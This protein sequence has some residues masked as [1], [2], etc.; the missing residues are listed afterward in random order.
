MKLAP[1]QF[2]NFI[3]PHNPQVFSIEFQRTM[4]LH[5]IP[6]GKHCLQNLG[7]NRRVMKGEGEF[8]GA[9]AYSQFKQ[10]AS[11]FYEETPGVLVHPL[12][13]S[14]KVYFVEL[15]LKQEPREN[16]VRYGFCFWEC[17]DALE[18][19]TLTEVKKPE[20]NASSGGQTKAEAARYHTV[21][22]G[23][24]LWKIAS[25]YDLTLNRILLL[26][27]QIKNPNLIR[28]GEQVRIA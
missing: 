15:F 13:Q 28:V 2:K 16:Y 7:M 9:S 6:F 20:S 8:V 24:S 22:S 26:N 27:P 18:Q 4:A 21:R 25:Q 10:L 1:M 23:D 17:F 3:W 14:S 12:W 11:L 19:A 5:K